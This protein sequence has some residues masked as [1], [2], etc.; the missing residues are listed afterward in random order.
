MDV[1]YGFLRQTIKKPIS[2]RNEI[3]KELDCTDYKKS[4]TPPLGA[5]CNRMAYLM[6]ASEWTAL[7]CIY[8]IY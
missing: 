8:P 3:F 2:C 1:K 4:Q 7:G 5:K 6:F